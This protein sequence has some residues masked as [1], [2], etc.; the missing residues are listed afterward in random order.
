[1]TNDQYRPTHVRDEQQTSNKYDKRILQLGHIFLDRY[2][3]FGIRQGGFGVVY[4]ATDLQTKQEFAIK[5]YKPEY[6]NSL[7]SINQFK[8]EASFWININPHPNIVRAYFVEVFQEQPY[9]FMDY[10]AGGSLRELLSKGALRTDQ[11]INFAYQLCLGMESANSNG[12]IAHCDLKPENILIDKNGIIK[13]SDFGLA[14][15]IEVRQGKYPMVD[16]G[17]WAYAAPEQFGITQQSVNSQ[18]DIYSFGIILF[19]ML[20]GNL[21]YP[22]G[23]SQEPETQYKELLHFHTNKGAHELAQEIYYK[24]INFISKTG[25]MVG[26]CIEHYTG[27]R[28]RDFT[29]L[30]KYIESEFDINTS[31]YPAKKTKDST[32]DD[33]HA[34]ALSLYKIGQYSE[35]LSIF[36]KLLQTYPDNGQIWLETAKTMIAMGQKV[37]AKKFLKKAYCLD[38]S[39]TEANHLLNS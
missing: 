39:L 27:N 25:Q 29:M 16:S 30:R 10:I 24:G 2:E 6:V 33:L 20:T 32:V 8:S 22:F 4:F 11:A 9:L 18:S 26:S 36:N 21:P 38:S 28:F 13:V 7:S 12:E 3:I 34:Q 15:Q 5:T 14:Q 23:L 37:P 35:A 31:D 17:T 19:E 1:M